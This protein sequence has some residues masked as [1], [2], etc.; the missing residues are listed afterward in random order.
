MSIKQ[1]QEILEETGIKILRACNGGDALKYCTENN[2]I[3]IVL[4]DI[5][6]PKINGLEATKKIKAIKKDLPIIAQTAAVYYDDKLKCKLA[7]C[8]GF[9]EK[10]I[11]IDKLI[12]MLIKWL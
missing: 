6:I 9:I 1:R 3:N 11:N 2:D 12:N 5:R 7:G 10:P 4:M 8:D